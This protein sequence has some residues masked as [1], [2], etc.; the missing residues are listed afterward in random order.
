MRVLFIGL[1]L[2]CGCAHVNETAFDRRTNNFQLCG[3]NWAAADDFEQEA[4]SVCAAPEQLACARTQR[5]GTCCEYHC[6]NGL[7]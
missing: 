6:P 2:L 1:A 3:N 7:P 5:G 4:R